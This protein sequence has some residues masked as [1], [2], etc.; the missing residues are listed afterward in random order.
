[1]KSAKDSEAADQISAFF[2]DHHSNSTV[3]LYNFAR[4]GMFEYFK[5]IKTAE[6]DEVIFQGFT[7]AAASLPAIWAGM[8]VKYVDIEEGSLVPSIQNI[9]EA[10]TPRTACIVAQYTLGVSPDLKALSELCKEKGISLIVDSTHFIPSASHPVH[11]IGDLFVYS[12]G[13]DKVI[14][15]VD[16]GVLVVRNGEVAQKISESYSSLSTPSKKWT[17]LRILFPFLWHTIKSTYTI[18]L[19]KLLHLIYTKTGL[20]S[21]STTPEEKIGVKPQFIPALPALP[22]LELALHQLKRI[23]SINEHRT[24]VSKIY[25]QMLSPI[26]EVKLY[27]NKT[28]LPQLRFPIEVENRDQLVK[29]LAKHSVIVGDWYDVPVAP[30]DIP[31]DVS[32]YN[33]GDAPVAESVGTRIINLPTHINIDEKSARTVAQLIISFYQEKDVPV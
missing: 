28:T 31:F 27:S 19:G 11:D 29:Y 15:G 30:S 14:S 21:R 33:V 24:K 8:N 5:A 4:S 12:F 7:C 13:R 17:L 10:I 16:G 18:K 22:L 23:E 32:D 1:M 26:P 25:N 2:K 3:F 9:E 6:K 20:L